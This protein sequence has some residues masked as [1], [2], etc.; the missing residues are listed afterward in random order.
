MLQSYAI[1]ATQR[2]TEV[3]VLV[4][5]RLAIKQT[6]DE[7]RIAF[8]EMLMQYLDAITTQTHVEGPDYIANT[9]SILNLT[10]RIARVVGPALGEG[11]TVSGVIYDDENGNG[12]RDAGEVGVAGA[13]VTLQGGD[14][15]VSVALVRTSITDA[16]GVYTFTGVPV[17]QYS[18]QVDLPGG[19]GR[20]NLPALT[21]NGS[22]PV[23]V[24][25]TAVQV[26]S[27]IYLPTLE[28]G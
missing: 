8:A 12:S 3:N 7:R 16:A 17:G 21:V 20:V 6:A 13:T 14:A 24:P 2:I 22:G 26:E 5:P 1:S 15:G 9:R 23:A 11:A 10:M 27:S 25:P 4:N 18:L 19:Q 28:K